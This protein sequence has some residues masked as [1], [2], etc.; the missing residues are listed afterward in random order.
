MP[1]TLQRG[2]TPREVARMLR[3]GRERIV[4]MIRRGELGALNLA[5]RRSGRPRYVILAHH[6]A[7]FEKGKQAADPPAPARRRR[8]VAPK[9][10]YPGD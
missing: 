9:D 4:A 5:A 7:E 6:L 2:H 10:Y 8:R 1:D 3:T